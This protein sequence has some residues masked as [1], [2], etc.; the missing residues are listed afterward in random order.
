MQSIRVHEQPMPSIASS[1]CPNGVAI[2]QSSFIRSCGRFATGS[3]LFSFKIADLFLF[4]AVALL[5][6]NLKV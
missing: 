3:V 5:P 1:F 4:Y 6:H 2:F